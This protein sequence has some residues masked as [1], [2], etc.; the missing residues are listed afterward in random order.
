MGVILRDRIRKMIDDL[1]RRVAETK[2]A[3]ST[4]CC[5]R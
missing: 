5:T 1:A 4:R 2:N 3:D